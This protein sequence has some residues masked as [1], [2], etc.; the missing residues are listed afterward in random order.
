MNQGK[1]SVRYAKALFSTAKDRK[2]LL[3]IKNDVELVSNALKT[4]KELTDFIY[5]PVA[6]PSQKKKFFSILL[7]KKVEKLTLD[8]LF[9]VIDNKRE[10]YL[11]DIFRVFNV[12]YKKSEGI[13][14]VTLTGTKEFSESQK[15]N[16]ISFIEKNFNTKVDL[17]EKIDASILGGFVLRIE[18]QQFDASVSNKLKEI[19]KELLESNK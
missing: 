12:L 16:V 13:K 14:T 15:K 11:S 3:A 18:D 6:K 1:I 19:K 10:T 2:N 7:E 4:I 5:S 17:E 9:L 8:F